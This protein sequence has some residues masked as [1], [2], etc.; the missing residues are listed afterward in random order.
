[1][2]SISL[3][4]RLHNSCCNYNYL[5]HSILGASVWMHGRRYHW[6]RTSRDTSFL[7]FCNGRVIGYI[8]I[9]TVYILST[10]L[11]YCPNESFLKSLIALFNLFPY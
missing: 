10:M 5:Q 6:E 9:D 8:D 1:M 2:E 3:S 4:V 7:L 11:P